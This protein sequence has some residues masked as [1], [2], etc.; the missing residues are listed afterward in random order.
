[1][2]LSKALFNNKCVILVMSEEIDGSGDLV[3]DSGL[4]STISGA[5]AALRFFFLEKS[6]KLKK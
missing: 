5:F 1:M 2:D 4:V 3:D 6:I